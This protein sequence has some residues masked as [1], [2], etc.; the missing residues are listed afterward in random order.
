MFALHVPLA[1]ISLMF[2]GGM[3]GNA[4][5]TL[6]SAGGYKNGFHPLE[7]SS[8]G[9]NKSLEIGSSNVL[10]S[11]SEFVLSGVITS[12]RSDSS[13][14]VVVVV[15]LRASNFFRTFEKSRERKSAAQYVSLSSVITIMQRS[16]WFC[17][18]LRA[19]K[20]GEVVSRR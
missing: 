18:S 11:L 1:C 9:R 16:S 10:D 7:R 2:R 17:A 19:N 20:L 6:H 3:H 8:F 4:Y 12:A 15:S 5:S 13:C 14:A